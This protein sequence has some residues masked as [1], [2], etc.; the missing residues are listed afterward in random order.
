MFIIGSFAFE[1]MFPKTTISDLS[2]IE[3]SL[4]LPAFSFGGPSVAQTLE[5]PAAQDRKP[6]TVERLAENSVPTVERLA[7]NS[8]QLV[9]HW[10]ESSTFEIP[11]LSIGGSSFVRDPTPTVESAENSV[12]TVEPLKENSVQLVE[13]WVGTSSA[14]EIPLLST[15]GSSLVRDPAVSESS[16]PTVERLKENSV[17]LVEH[18]V[19]TSS[20]F[21]IPLL[22]IGGSSFVRDPTPTVESV[23]NSVPTTKFLDATN[24]DSK[25]LLT[26]RRN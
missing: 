8:V 2:R 16:V 21:E 9:E 22:S 1:T 15:G 4:R 10:V 7:E 13:R 23:E 17:Q 24:Q 19:G 18:W 3:T 12:P 11:L 20:T 26:S 6:P 5:P 25:K 14:F